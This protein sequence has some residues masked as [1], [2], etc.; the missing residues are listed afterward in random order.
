MTIELRKTGIS[1][2][3]D[4]QCNDHIL[5]ESTQRYLIF[6]VLFEIS[7]YGIISVANFFVCILNFVQDLFINNNILLLLICIQSCQHSINL[8]FYYFFKWSE[9][10]YY[11]FELFT[12]FYCFIGYFLF[13]LLVLLVLPNKFEKICNFLVLQ[14][15]YLIKCITKIFSIKQYINLINY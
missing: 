14:G 1:K 7:V 9:L 13:S 4:T 2:L 11:I 15:H 12:I 6:L 3:T 10:L 5:I 8:I